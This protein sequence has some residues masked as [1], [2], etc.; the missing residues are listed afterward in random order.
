MKRITLLDGGVGQEVYKRAGK[1]DSPM[2][3]AQMTLE[4][5]G[6]VKAVHRDFIRAG[7]RVITI[8]TYSCTP[9]RLRRD[10][11]I[12]W[13]EPLQRQ[14]YEIAALAR[15]ELASEAPDV[16]IAACLPP[17]IGSYT[18]DDRSFSALKAEYDAIV[19]LQA[20]RADLFLIETIADLKEARAAVEAALPS[21]KP[22]LLS[23]TVSDD[24]A[25]KLRGGEPVEEA[26]RLVSAY[27][28]GGLLFNCSS[29]ETITEALEAMGNPGIPYGGY[30][31]AFT[32]VAPLRPGGLV[33]RLSARCNLEEEQYTEFAMRWV[34][35]GATIVGGCCEVGPSYIQAVCGALKR[36]GYSI[37]A[38]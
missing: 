12:E 26:A 25:G 6:L 27:A 22:V 13:F 21:G 8:N 14:A 17:L 29:P 7:S 28:L 19:A 33:N 32:S 18:T 31:N 4:R 30:A 5:P 16:Q 38:V 24:A 2:W 10:G 3:S 15:A 20:A 36:N 34:E 23:F 35:N 9:S 37:T 11:E 1:P